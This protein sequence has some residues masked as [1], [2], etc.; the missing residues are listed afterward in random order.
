MDLTS[1]TY[2]P[3]DISFSQ[4]SSILEKQIIEVNE[5]TF[6]VIDDQIKDQMIQEIEKAAAEGDSLGGYFRN[7]SYRSSC[8]TRRTFL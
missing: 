7:R 6:A 5:K 4:N 3:S 1:K 2:T 8:R